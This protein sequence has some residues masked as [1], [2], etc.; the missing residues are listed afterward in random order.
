MLRTVIPNIDEELARI[1]AVATSGYIIGFNM[2]WRGPEHILF[3]YPDEWKRVYEERNYFL[4]DPVL[5]WTIVG[6]GYK[7]WSAITARDPLD[8]LRVMRAARKYGLVFGA[9]FTLKVGNKRSLMSVARA[10]RE[11]TDGELEMLNAKFAGFVD[12]LM[13]KALLT[14][15]ELA[16][17]QYMRDGYEQ[18]E[19]AGV[20]KISRSAVKQR[21]Q[22][23]CAKLNARNSAQAI[24]ICVAR[25]YFDDAPP[26]IS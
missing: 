26:P 7:R 12:L 10:D 25:H 3:G 15:G 1:R 4:S 2:T 21:V 23:A 6:S 16:V 20:L 17:L 19:V 9:A 11:L 14:D 22:K 5:R 8:P 24:A 18:Q 13:S